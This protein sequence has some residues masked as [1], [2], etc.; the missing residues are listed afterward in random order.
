MTLQEYIL[1]FR[2]EH[3]LSQRQFSS[4]ANLSNSYLAIIENNYNPKTGRAPIISLLTIKK[5][6]AAMGLSLQ[7]LTDIIDNQEIADYDEAVL[8]EDERHLIQY[9]RDM[10]LSQKNLLLSVASAIVK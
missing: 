3:N 6:A 4:I 9:Y 7:E 1:N 5:L 8:S 2:K 10:T